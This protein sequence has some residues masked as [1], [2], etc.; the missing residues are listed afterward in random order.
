MIVNPSFAPAVRKPCETLSIKEVRKCIP[1]FGTP[2]LEQ[3]LQKFPATQVK[4]CGWQLEPHYY[5]ALDTADYF[6]EPSKNGYAPV[7]HANKIYAK[8]ESIHLAD[9]MNK[10]AVCRRLIDSTGVLLVTNLCV[11]TWGALHST[12]ETGCVRFFRFAGPVDFIQLDHFWTRAIVL[13][14]FQFACG[15]E[16]VSFSKHSVVR[17]M[18]EHNAQTFEWRV[19]GEV[20]R[21]LWNSASDIEPERD[22]E[23]IMTEDEKKE[24]EVSLPQIPPSRVAEMFSASKID[25][26]KKFVS[27]RDVEQEL[28]ERREQSETLV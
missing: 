7:D 23:G 25:N 20:L 19:R 27:V 24:W 6:F 5:I 8:H 4:Y 17:L 15:N 18:I 26:C 16:K 13:Y 2:E 28:F 21:K 14:S 3:H 22:P 11:P 9:C 10:N 1:A 12:R